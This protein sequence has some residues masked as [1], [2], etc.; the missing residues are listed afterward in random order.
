[1]R[2]SKCGLKETAARDT[3]VFHRSIFVSVIS[4]FEIDGSA[5]YIEQYHTEL[6]VSYC[7]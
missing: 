3:F 6:I 1:M 7:S 2:R 5:L 4:N